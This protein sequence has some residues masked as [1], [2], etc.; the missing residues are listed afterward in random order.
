M[1]GSS[2]QHDIRYKFSRLP[3]TDETDY[4]FFDVFPGFWM[5]RHDPSFEAMMHNHN[6]WNIV[7]YGFVVSVISVATWKWLGM[8][9]RIGKRPLF[10]V[11]KRTWINTKVPRRRARFYDTYIFKLPKD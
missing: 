6:L 11:N 5:L 2:K 10:V 8:A 7:S 4:S 1:S 9:N 3:M